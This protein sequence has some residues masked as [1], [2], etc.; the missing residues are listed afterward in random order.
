MPS[1]LPKNFRKELAELSPEE[2][3]KQSEIT[4]RSVKKSSFM[5]EVDLPFF[6]STKREK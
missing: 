4:N 5:K 1:H 6:Y 3:R 2:R